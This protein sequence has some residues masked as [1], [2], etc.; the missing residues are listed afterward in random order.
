MK[1]FFIDCDGTLCD[2]LSIW[3]HLAEDDLR[4]R[5]ISPRADLNAAI[6]S[7]NLHQAAAYIKE[8]YALACGTE[9][10]L[11][12]WEA[13]LEDFYRYEAPAKAGAGAF[14]KGAR[15]LGIAC[16]CVSLT[17]EGLIRPLL[18][19]VG[20]LDDLDAVF[21]GHELDLGKDSPA[22]YT[23]AASQVGLRPADGVVIEDSHFALQ[24]AAAA[25]FHCWA[26][27]DDFHGSDHN[28][29]LA[30]DADAVLQSWQEGLDRL[31]CL[32]EDL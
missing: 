30:G 14:L 21:S 22:L 23:Y 8:S 25:G 2:T 9:D 4:A 27:L 1:A 12:A 7:Y 3:R 17:P 10:L 18:K 26:F 16:Y 13:R 29:A 28:R 11:T 19:R 31:A 6:A 15:A 32:N 5:G 20:L 24:T